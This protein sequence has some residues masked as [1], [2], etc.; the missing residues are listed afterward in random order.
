MRGTRLTLRLSSALHAKLAADPN[1]LHATLAE[2]RAAVRAAVP[3]P[4]LAIA[5]DATL[6]DREAA[7]A[8]DATPVAWL[9]IAS[10]EDLRAALPAA[11]ALVAPELIGVD[12]VA[13]LVERAAVASPVLVREVVPRMI[14][15]PMLAEVLRG[16]ARERVPLDDLAAVLEAIAVA[17]APADGKPREVAALIEHLRGQL[18]RQ[19]SARWAPRGQLAVF[20]VDA[21]IEDALRTSID[22][23]DGG[24]VLALEPAIAQDIVAAVRAGVGSG[25]AVIL[26]S[27][28][29]AA[30]CAR[31]SSRSCPTSR[32][33]PRTSWRP[34]R[35]SARPAGSRCDPR[36][37]RGGGGARVAR[38]AGGRGSAR[39]ARQR[40]RGWLAAA[41]R[42]R[43]RAPAHRG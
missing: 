29:V 36:G 11:L 34:A 8:I 28:D 32:S 17:P 41:H 12:L 35:R 24:S 37:G 1:A 25:P 33:S 5:R 39:V 27:S 43:R 22:R 10:L 23:R 42:R 7:L 15:L 20:T 2:A 4:P 9:A 30:T 38:I 31:C 18:R 26:T 13:L 6:A 16:L 19:I 3:V 21:M 14:A 40:R